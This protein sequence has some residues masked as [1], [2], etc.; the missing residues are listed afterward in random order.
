MHRF[1]HWLTRIDTDLLEDR[2]QGR[3]E[4]VKGFLGFPDIENLKAVASA[5]THVVEATCERAGASGLQPS[6]Y[7]IVLIGTIEASRK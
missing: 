4:I 3:T 5:E 1:N 6:N 7:V 2:H